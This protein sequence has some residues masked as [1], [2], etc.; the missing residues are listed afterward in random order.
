MRWL[1]LE[2][3]GAAKARE[4]ELSAEAGYPHPAT[5]TDR[6]VEAIS[7]IDGR[8]ALPVPSVVW[9][10]A[11]GCE[12]DLSAL[13]TEVEAASLHSL[14]EMAEGGWFDTVEIL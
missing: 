4:V 1:V 10:W 8:G 12:I 2:T 3:A 6:I 9:S 14:I 5:A 7:H 11:H 13:L